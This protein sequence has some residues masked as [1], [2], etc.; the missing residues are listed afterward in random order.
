M[1]WKLERHS[2][3]SLRQ[4]EDRLEQHNIAVALEHRYFIMKQFGCKIHITIQ[5]NEQAVK[6]TWATMIRYML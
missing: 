1:Y 2:F 4:A 5:F 6:L 3:C